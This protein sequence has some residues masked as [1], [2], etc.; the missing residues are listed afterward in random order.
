[1]VGIAVR[2]GV[3]VPRT[4][5]R[6]HCN[7]A[8]ARGDPASRPPPTPAT[9]QVLSQGAAGETTPTIGLNVKVLKKGN[10]VIKAWDLGGQQSYR[11]EWSRYARG[12]DV[13]IFVVDA[14]DAARV[15]VARKELHRLLEDPALA[16]TPLL[17]AA[18]KVRGRSGGGQS[19]H[20]RPTVRHLPRT[21]PHPA[22]PH[23]TTQIDIVPHL[24][25]EALIKSLNLD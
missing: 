4:A 6:S 13:I 9:L 24:S 23:R 12:V 18:N 2:P 19:R 16:H 3:R 5:W 7:Q 21:P 17:V 11:P 15:P 22:P 10:V 20:A 1:M 14:A 8:W 25:E